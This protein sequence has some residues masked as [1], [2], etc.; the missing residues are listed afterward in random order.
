M[1]SAVRR[2]ITQPENEYRISNF[3][4]LK[5][6]AKNVLIV[7]V[8]IEKDSKQIKNVCGVIKIPPGKVEFSNYPW[9]TNIIFSECDTMLKGKIITLKEISQRI[10]NKNRVES[11]NISIEIPMLVNEEIKYKY[12]EMQSVTLDDINSHISIR[13]I[14]L[15][16]HKKANIVWYPFA[17]SYDLLSGT[18]HTIGAPFGMACLYGV[19]NNNTFIFFASLPFCGIYKVFSFLDEIDL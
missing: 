4:S 13:D 1:T 9:S 14:S 16:K 17:F 11:F 5:Q 6:S 19:G 8:D 3:I 2:S 15:S 10:W 12:F 7:E 18:L